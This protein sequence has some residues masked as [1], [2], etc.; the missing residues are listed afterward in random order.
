MEEVTDVIGNGFTGSITE[1]DS[2]DVKGWG[3]VG[4]GGVRVQALF[5]E[6]CSLACDRH[7]ALLLT[8]L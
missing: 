7:T 3:V 5:C 1:A 4:G 2:R 8:S 6:S